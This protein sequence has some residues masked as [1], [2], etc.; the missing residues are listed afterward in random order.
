MM[1]RR[2]PFEHFDR[3]VRQMFERM[4]RPIDMSGG[5]NPTYVDQSINKDDEL[6]VTIDIPGVSKEDIDVEVREDDRGRQV[7]V[8]NTEES[9]EGR[10][11]SFTQQIQLKDRVD[12]QTG[13]AEYNNGVLTVRFS[14][15]DSD[16]KTEIK[17]E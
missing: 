4:G 12:P 14:M 7:L 15:T 17:V 2:D 16:S 1:P 6:R 10:Q 9:D 13:T 3:T 11:R 5:T 8:I